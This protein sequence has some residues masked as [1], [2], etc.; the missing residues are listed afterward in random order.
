MFPSGYEQRILAHPIQQT[1]NKRHS[2]GNASIHLYVHIYIHFLRGPFCDIYPVSGGDLSRVHALLGST[3]ASA[4]NFSRRQVSNSS[5]EIP[6]KKQ[7]RKKVLHLR[8]RISRDLL[9]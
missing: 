9:E 3:G 1:S 4:I 6:K 5:F 7:R 2:I 8:S